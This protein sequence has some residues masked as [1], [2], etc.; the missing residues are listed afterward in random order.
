MDS[1]A[2]GEKEQGDIAYAAKDYNA[3][4]MHYE[5]VIASGDTNLDTMSKIA[6]AYFLV[7]QYDLAETFAKRAIAAKDGNQKPPFLAY[8]ALLSCLFIKKDSNQIISISNE[9]INFAQ[10]AV[11]KSYGLAY[12]GLG[13]YL[14]EKFEEAL[15]DFNESLKL[16]PYNTLALEYRGTMYF[17]QKRYVE[18]LQDLQKVIKLSPKNKVAITLIPKLERIVGI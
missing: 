10:S 5:K 15:N 16:D 17:K 14:W 18:S 7:K 8:V 6:M 1:I 2:N 11:E 4:I 9:V 12:R 13:Y 3:A